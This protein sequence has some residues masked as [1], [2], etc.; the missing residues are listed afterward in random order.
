MKRLHVLVEGQTE[1][2]FV[3]DVLTP[4][5]TGKGIHPTSIL[6]KTKRVK[7]GG[8]FRGGVTSTQQVLDDIARLLCDSGV[9]AVTTILDYYGLP[10]DFPGFSSR[11]MG[12]PYD[13]VTHVETALFDRFKTPR[14]IPHLVLHEFESW[15]F[16]NPP[17]CN[18]VFDDPSVIGQLVSIRATAG[19]AEQINDGPTT[20]PSKRLAEVFPSYR[21]TLHGPIAVGAIGLPAVRAACQQ[22][23][24]WLK[25]L[26]AL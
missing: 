3:R 26:E 19:G 8:A 15:I 9:A 24:Q 14:F 10:P 20:A 21:K 7:S 2:V 22:A 25:Q 5:L 6:L 12:N 13:R 17:A 1:D 11:P 4:H 18:W 23:D 16:S